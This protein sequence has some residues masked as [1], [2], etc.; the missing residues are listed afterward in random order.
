M[1]G[2]YRF[3]QLFG[4][5]NSVNPQ[6]LLRVSSEALKSYLHIEAEPV[7]HMVTV[8]QVCLTIIFD[9]FC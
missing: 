6:E 8:H 2:G 1:L 4:Q 3:A 5:P 9:N 7:Q